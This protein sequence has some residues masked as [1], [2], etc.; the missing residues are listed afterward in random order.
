MIRD[1][2]RTEGLRA[3]LE[4]KE[5]ILVNDR[6]NGLMVSLEKWPS[7]RCNYSLNFRNTSR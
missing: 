5:T 4:L 1:R 3:A 7:V 6:D 2:K